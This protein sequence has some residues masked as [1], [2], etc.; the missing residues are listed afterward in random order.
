MIDL[1]HAW[2]DMPPPGDLG[3]SDHGRERSRPGAGQPVA[4]VAE[5]DTSYVCVVD[6]WGNAF[7]ATPSDGPSSPV[8]PDLGII[9]SS[10]GYQAWAD[11]SHPASIAPRKRPRLTPSPGM[12]LKDGELSITYGTPGND[13]QPQAMV[14]FLVNVLDFGMDPQA[15]VDAARFASYSFPATGHPHRSE[16]GV[17]RLESGIPASAR[18]DLL[19]RGHLVQG[20]SAD[21]FEDF[22][23]VC[24]VQV[25]AHG[26]LVGGADP[27]R[28][29]CALGW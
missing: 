11:A 6:R 21:R 20:A 4:H 25:D 27:R 5:P 19:K 9:A 7:S 29:S 23:A 14:Q 24:A 13:R 17:V 2:A 16:P 8:I 18:A 10:R 1:A 28:P 12:V 22:G 26:S 15:A 3:G